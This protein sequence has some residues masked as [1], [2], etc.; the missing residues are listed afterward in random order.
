MSKNKHVIIAGGKTGGHLFPGIAVAQALMEKD[1]S[2]KILFVG[3]NAP[4]ETD[5]LARYGFAHK[6]IISR[7]IKGKNLFAKAW[8]AGLVGISLIQALVIIIGFRANFIL[9][10]GGFSSFALVLAGRILFR[11]TAI[12]EQNAF[13]GM[14]NRMLSKIARTRF[15]SFKETKGMPENDTTFLVGNPVRR[16]LNTPLENIKT[17]DSVL[18]RINADDFLILVTGGSQGAASINGAF[19]DAVAMMKETSRLFIIHQ[20][21]KNAETQIQQFYAAG[22]IRHKAAAFFY[23]MPAIQDRAD[24][25]ISRAGAGTVSELCIKGKPAIL[26][27]YPHAADDHQTAN[28]QFLADQGACIMIADKDLTGQTLLAAIG[29]LQ[30]NTK[31]RSD[32]ANAMKTLAMPHGADLIADRI[33]GANTLK[34]E[35]NV[36]A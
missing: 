14:T 25:V 34:K 11:E 12:H 2:T 30:H 6:S 32:M 8:S 28:A 21:G 29:D 31:K 10:V 15:I 16:P 20:T 33:I 35:D 3:T 22:D 13:P 18:N 17:D 19:T 24:L 9:G 1:P 5:T 36:P 26:V 7:P 27:P 4:F 23:D